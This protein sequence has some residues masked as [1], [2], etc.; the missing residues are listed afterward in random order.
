VRRQRETVGEA[1]KAG[2]C[3]ARWLRLGGAAL[4]VASDGGPG[5][6]ASSPSPRRR[7][8]TMAQAA[9]CRALHQ[10]G[11]GRRQP[12]QRDVEPVTE[13]ARSCGADEA[14]R[15]CGQPGRGGERRPL[16][17]KVSS[18]PREPRRATIRMILVHLKPCSIRNHPVSYTGRF[19]HP[20]Y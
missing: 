5:G 11:I 16:W 6:A 14:A 3:G 4:G 19:S 1:A 2:Q 9:W 13:A 12:R 20:V 17:P 15:S 18:S 10:G 7:Q 8:A